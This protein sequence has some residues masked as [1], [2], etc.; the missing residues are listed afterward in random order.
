MATTIIIH[1]VKSP[2]KMNSNHH[3]AAIE[4]FGDSDHS[5]ERILQ[6]LDRHSMSAGQLAT[7]IEEVF[8]ENDIEG[9]SIGIAAVSLTYPDHDSDEYLDLTS[10]ILNSRCPLLRLQS[11]PNFPPE[12]ERRAEEMVEIVFDAA[13]RLAAGFPLAI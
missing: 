7:A 6:V 10:R 11:E 2:V 4:L 3:K 12:L 13:E 1:P 5:E 9:A 8:S